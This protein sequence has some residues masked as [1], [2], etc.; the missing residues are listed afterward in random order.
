MTP[1]EERRALRRE[2]REI[3]RDYPDGGP[4]DVMADR[5]RAIVNRLDKLCQK[6]L[7]KAADARRR[8]GDQSVAAKVPS[9]VSEAAAAVPQELTI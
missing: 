8:P 2:L 1:Q 7:R 5:R 3:E 4:A 9:P 6:S